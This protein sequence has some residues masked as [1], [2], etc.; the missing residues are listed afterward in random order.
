MSYPGPGMCDGY[1]N[2]STAIAGYSGENSG[3][4]CAQDWKC[5]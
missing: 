3:I 1:V 5:P 4:S 2:Y